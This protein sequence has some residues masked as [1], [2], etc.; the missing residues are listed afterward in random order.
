MARDLIAHTAKLA[1]K[2]KTATGV[3]LANML[4]ID[5][6]PWCGRC[7]D[8]F[9][10]DRLAGTPLVCGHQRID[11][12]LIKIDPDP[13]AGPQTSQAATGKRLGGS[14]QNR[15]AGRRSALASI[16]QRW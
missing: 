8:V 15:W 7:W 6:L 16:A 14:I 9:P 4:P 3:Q 2:I 1:G 10:T 5:L 11:L 13:I 12:A